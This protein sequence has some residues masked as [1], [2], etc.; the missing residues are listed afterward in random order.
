[1]INGL[2]VLQALY[3]A[4]LALFA[5]KAV[6]ADNKIP[7]TGLWPVAIFSLVNLDWLDTALTVIDTLK[8]RLKF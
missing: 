7:A 1:M 3:P 5:F 8:I 4:G 6:S 2:A